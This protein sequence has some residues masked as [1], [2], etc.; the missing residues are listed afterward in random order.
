VINIVEEYLSNVSRC[1]R[2]RQRKEVVVFGEGIDDHQYRVGMIKVG[3]TIHEIHRDHLPRR[4]GHMQGLK[5]TWKTGPIRFSALANETRFDKIVNSRLHPS[6]G[7]DLLQLHIGD[8][9][10][11]MATEHTGMGGFDDFLL[12]N[13]IGIDPNAMIIWNR[14]SR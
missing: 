13:R 10:T 2:V 6:P 3:Q 5:K 14:W 4:G 8:Q 7:K 12:E 1:K 11:Q 9:K